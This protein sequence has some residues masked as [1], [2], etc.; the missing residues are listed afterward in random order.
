MSFSICHRSP[1]SAP[2]SDHICRDCQFPASCLVD[3]TGKTHPT[4]SL[5]HSQEAH[6]FHSVYHIVGLALPV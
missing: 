5:F 6:T 4:P 2:L 3:G 1:Y